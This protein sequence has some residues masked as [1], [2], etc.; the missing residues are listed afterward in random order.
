MLL[1]LRR[2]PRW[3]KALI[4]DPTLRR[5]QEQTKLCPILVWVCA[6]IAS[7]NARVGARLTAATNC[8]GVQIRNALTHRTVVQLLVPVARAV[9]R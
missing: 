2:R 8:V 3:R 5:Q 4:L 9:S 1:P 6:A 7:R